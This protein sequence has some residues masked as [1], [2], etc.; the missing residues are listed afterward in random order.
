VAGEARR[1]LV[2]QPTGVTS[3]AWIGGG[4]WILTGHSSKVLRLTDPHRGK[5]IATLRGPEALV[6]LLVLSPDGRHLAVSSHDR[7]VRIYDLA[8]REQVAQL[9]P[10]K[11]PATALCFLADGGFL[12]T[13]CQDNSIQLFDLESHSLAATLWGPADES[14]VGLALFGESNHLA[15]ALADGRIRVWG[16][17]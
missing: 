9:A 1:E 5:L 8:T 12:A 15:A 14:F 16:P 2:R 4:E 6:N 7:V 3:L 17:S 10:L 13:V 11:R